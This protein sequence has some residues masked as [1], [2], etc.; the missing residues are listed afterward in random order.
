VKII[1]IQTSGGYITLSTTYVDPEQPGKFVHIQNRH[2]VIPIN[3]NDKYEWVVLFE[4]FSYLTALLDKQDKIRNVMIKE[5]NK[6]LPVDINQTVSKVMD[7]SVDR[8]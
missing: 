6:I 7:I 5:R 4:L 1:S 2:A 8:T 3:S